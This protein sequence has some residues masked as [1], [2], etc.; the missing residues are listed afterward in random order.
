MVEDDR[1]DPVLVMGP[2]RTD[3]IRSKPARNPGFRYGL[4]GNWI[5]Y[6]QPRDWIDLISVD[7]TVAGERLGFSKSLAGFP[8]HTDG[9]DL[10]Y[11]KQHRRLLSPEHRLGVTRQHQRGEKCSTRTHRRA[12][13]RVRPR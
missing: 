4:P 3:A 8:G 12:S 5:E 9:A 6:R 13:H 2:S 1:R 11:G 7:H 10:Y